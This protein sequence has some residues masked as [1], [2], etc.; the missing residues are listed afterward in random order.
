N[1]QSAVILAA[2]VSFL[3]IQSVDQGGDLVFKR[4]PAQW[5]SY[6]SALYSIGSITLGLL[7]VT[8]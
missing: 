5:A 2:N 7:L 4:S 3:S 1:T 8:R 6:L